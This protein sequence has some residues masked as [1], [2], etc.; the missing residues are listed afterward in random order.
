MANPSRY[1]SNDADSVIVI[2][3][4]DVLPA[5][6]LPPPETADDSADL[7]RGPSEDGVGWDNAAHWHRAVPGSDPEPAPEPEP[8]PKAEPEPEPKAEPEP[9]PKAEPESEAEP[10]ADL[11]PGPEPVADLGSEPESG[12]GPEPED[13]PALADPVPEPILRPAADASP[14]SGQAAPASERDRWREILS[15]FVD[16]PRAA[17][18]E[19]AMLADQEVTAW[20]DRLRQRQEALR[21]GW[22][23]GKN[24]GTEEYRIALRAY[25]D[26]SR[27]LD[28]V[29]SVL[30]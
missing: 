28:A 7:G 1:D 19:A 12:L 17:V 15:G 30:A 21:E 16:D 5:D 8:E 14:G 23:D 26:L 29:A 27:Q 24:P 10:V 13:D 22:Q 18:T 9:E 25:R 6:N 20:T 2:E 3:P 4:E 11:G